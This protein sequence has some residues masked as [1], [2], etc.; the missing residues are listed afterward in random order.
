MVVVIGGGEQCYGLYYIEA[1]D[2]ATYFTVHRTSPHNRE[3]L[4]PNVSSTRVEKPSECL[5]RSCLESVCKIA[6][7]KLINRKPGKSKVL[8]TVGGEKL[9][10]EGYQQC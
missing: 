6:G 3:T 10:T 7:M 4:T 2:A 1:R 9:K 5:N 8:E